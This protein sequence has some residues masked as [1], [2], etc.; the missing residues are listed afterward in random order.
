MESRW[1]LA[2][3]GGAGWRDW[4]IIKGTHGH[5]QRWWLMG[6]EGI[7]GLNGNGKTYTK[8]YCTYRLMLGCPLQLLLVA[9]FMICLFLS[10]HGQCVC[11]SSAGGRVASC[12]FFKMQWISVCLLIRLFNL[13]TGNVPMDVGG[14]SFALTLFFCSV[15]FSSLAPPFLL[16]FVFRCFSI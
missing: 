4:T 13:F 16:S 8:D 14:L 10:F 6:V 7:R 9:A 2:G 11:V 1:Q 15:S 3:R 5:G 12:R